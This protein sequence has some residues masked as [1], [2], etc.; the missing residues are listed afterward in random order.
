MARFKYMI[1]IM[2]T[3]FSG[4]PT[5][6][7]SDSDWKY[8]AEPYLLAASIEGDVGTGRVTGAPVDVDFGDIL[9]NLE[10]GFMIHLEANKADK[11]GIMFDYGFM[12]LAADIS[13]PVGGIINAEVSQDIMELFFFKRFKKNSDIY[14]VYI[15]LRDWDMDID[16]QVDPLVLPGTAN[17]AID[18]S[19]TDPVIGMRY[20]HPLSDTWTG[21]LRGDIGGFGVGSDSTYLVA[22]GAQYKIKKDM[23]LNLKYQGLWVDY[24]DGTPGTPGYFSYDTVT[25]GPYI[26]I[27]FDF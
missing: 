10:M 19:W 2:A 1:L 18:E 9:E 4:L 22:V 6:A 11:W 5:S 26:G 13:G 12:D 27:H 20:F 8:F 16:I 14:D 3:C 25:H 15:G 7:L 17:V 23:E 21:H 24:E